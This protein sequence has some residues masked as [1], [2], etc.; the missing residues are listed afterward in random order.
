VKL[1]NLGGYAERIRCARAVFLDWDGCLAQDGALLPGVADFLGEVGDRAWILSNNSTDLPAAF[2]EMLARAGVEMSPERVLLAGDV[3]VTLT[4]A[5]PNLGPVH[6]VAAARMKVRARSL[7][8]EL[9]R[10][11]REARYPVLLC[12]A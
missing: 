5:H 3:A 8:I 2:V 4:A 11:G 9:D 7:G 12:Q 10:D 1:A 6:M